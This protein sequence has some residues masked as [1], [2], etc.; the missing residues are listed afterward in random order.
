MPFLPKL[1]LKKISITIFTT[2]CINTYVLQCDEKTIPINNILLKAAQEGDI[3]K[4]KAALSSGAYVD[5]Q[6][7]NNLTPLH[8]AARAGH[9]DI[10]QEL[11]HAGA[12]IQAKNKN[13]N[14]PLHSAAYGNQALAVCTLILKGADLKAQ[15]KDGDTPLHSAAWKPSKDRQ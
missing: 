3:E 7:D 11:L 8:L 5:A 12:N 2:L 13:N 9:F 4:V 15:N 14:T 6:G 1:F 10:I